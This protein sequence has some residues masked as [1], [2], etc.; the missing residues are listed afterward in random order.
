LVLRN[1]A[2]ETTFYASPDTGNLY[3]SGT[4]NG[5]TLRI[6]DEAD[7]ELGNEGRTLD[8]YLGA[9]FPTKDEVEHTLG[10]LKHDTD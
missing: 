6:A 7:W 8:A 1:W 4:L 2:G 5:N 3:I 9:N 10:E